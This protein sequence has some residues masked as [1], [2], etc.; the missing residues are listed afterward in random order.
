MQFVLR[1]SVLTRNLTQLAP[2]AMY[3][4]YAKLLL[5]RILVCVCV[6]VCVC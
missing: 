5:C 2:C 1:L 4:K 6:C 3:Q